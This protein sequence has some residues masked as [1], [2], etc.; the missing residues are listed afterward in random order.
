[1]GEK[2]MVN[3][4]FPQ[5][6]LD[7]KYSY[8]Y[9]TPY[10]SPDC[11]NVRN[12]GSIDRRERGGNRAGLGKA[13]NQQIGSG[14]PVRM[15]DEV[16]HVSDSGY[17]YFIDNFNGAVLANNWIVAPWT[18]GLPPVLGGGAVNETGDVG[19]V[20]KLIPAAT[21]STQFISILI[22]PENNTFA[23]KY[24][25]F[26]RMDNTT[27]NATVDGIIVE[28]VMDDD[29]GDYTG[30]LKTY[31][32]SS[33]TTF[34]LTA[35]SLGAV[36][37]VWLKVTSSADN[38]T[39]ELGEDV[40]INSQ[41]VDAHTGVRAG[42][43]MEATLTGERALIDTYLYEFFDVSLV[44]RPRRILV[45]SSDGELWVED[46]YNTLRQVSTSTTLANDRRISSQERTQ[47]LFI[48][49]YGQVNEAQIDGV[50]SGTSFTSASVAD[51]TALGISVDD[52]QLSILLPI[53]KAGTY[54]IASIASGALTMAISIGNISNV[55]FRVERCP[56][57][58][59][60]SDDTLIKWEATSGFVPLG[61]RLIC[62]YRDRLV[63]GGALTTPHIWFMSKQGD[64]LDFDFS[65]GS[66]P[67]NVQR[68]VAGTNTTAGLIGDD[69]TALI[70]F[71]DDFLIFGCKTSLWI[72]RGDPASNGY[73][74]NISS[75]LG[76]LDENA[77]CRGPSGELIFLSRDGLYRLAP[78]G[79]GFPERISRNKIPEEMLD[80]EVNSNTISLEYDLREEG[81][82]IYITPNDSAENSHFYYDYETS[83]F[84]PD[85]YNFNHE[86][87][88]SHY[89]VTDVAEN[90]GV[91]LGCR[92]GYIR[93]HF[94][95]NA[96]DDGIS[97]E[98]FVLI[99]PIRLSK[100]EYREGLLMELW[101]VLALN[102]NEVQWEVRPGKT[103]E[104][105]VFAD[106]LFSGTWTGEGTGL[107]FKER[108][109]VRGQSICI[110]V[111]ST[112][113]SIWSLERLTAIVKR[114][115]KL[116]RS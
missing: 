30:T 74:D 92:D 27:P 97:F 96:N 104:E 13:F 56:K 16:K 4:L 20:N 22:S 113:N 62:L 28:I 76:I 53:D 5:G 25:V 106:P 91:L 108:P 33:L 18:S 114:T 67:L 23:G 24:Q 17:D 46:T 10:S 102:S 29:T 58:Y 84:F 78:G 100:S 90:T 51:W 101:A 86:P 50:I 82:H 3:L 70:P 39:V 63:L 94:R 59:N 47:E 64:P 21:G 57:I 99:G 31:A 89:Y 83:S 32:S 49:D 7:R 103:R 98:S 14:N 41:A 71:S 115:G 52:H 11:L 40:L 45:A 69:L 85:T 110:K 36:K 26:A 75:V 116:R 44:E 6:G 8:Q 95:N 105:S 81:I 109:R 93:K 48:A 37:S 38:I 68:A 35:G 60:P 87:F 55:S 54:S 66:D 34:V 72:L 88:E 9:Q 61:N 42:F 107:N 77:W 15:L 19:A 79:Q 80:L 112:G 12:D 73:I 2:G 65:G 1:M 111:G 43:G